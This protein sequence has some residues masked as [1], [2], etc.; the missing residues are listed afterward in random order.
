MRSRFATER[1][2]RCDSRHALAEK[3]HVTGHVEYS[4]IREKLKY[5]NTVVLRSVAF[6]LYKLEIL[7]QACTLSKVRPFES[8]ITNCI[9][10][11]E[12]PDTACYHY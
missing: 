9:F 6:F 7:L 11:N 3:D 5:L 12:L 1:R 8:V 2:I 4:E 10:L